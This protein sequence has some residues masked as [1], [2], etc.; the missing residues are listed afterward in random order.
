MFAIILGMQR[1]EFSG[2][3]D[4]PCPMPNNWPY[5]LLRVSC[6]QDAYGRNCAAICGQEIV[7]RT[8]DLATGQSEIDTALGLTNAQFRLTGTPAGLAPEE[9]RDSVSHTVFPLRE[10]RPIYEGKVFVNHADLYLTL[11]NAEKLEE[12]NWYNN[13]AL[14]EE[15][16]KKGFN[17]WCFE[18]DEGEV[19]ELRRSSSS[20]DH[21]D[22]SFRMGAST[23]WNTHASPLLLVR[24]ARRPGGAY[25]ISEYFS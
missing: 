3:P 24:E 19:S 14:D 9:I 8:V 20:M 6:E 23:L 21:Y 15:R 10:K 12:A 7:A 11:L 2:N 13:Y 25:P 16:V 1:C 22:Q 17:W 5:A 4:K 18:S